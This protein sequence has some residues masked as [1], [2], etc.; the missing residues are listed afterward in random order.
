VPVACPLLVLFTIA[1]ECSISQL[2]LSKC[3]SAALHF[4]AER[5]F[6]DLRSE[7]SCRVL[8]N[9]GS[10][11]SKAASSQLVG[12]PVPGAVDGA[13]DAAHDPAGPG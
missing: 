9:H 10:V 13:A 1:G 3:A 8:R 4:N 6:P 5:L 7:K 12:H 11:Q 2:F